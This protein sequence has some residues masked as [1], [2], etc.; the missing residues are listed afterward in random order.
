MA[1]NV[2]KRAT[3]VVVRQRRVETSAPGTGGSGIVGA[4]DAKSETP[5]SPNPWPAEFGWDFPFDFPKR[6]R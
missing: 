3:D 5:Q 6:T 2:Q 4:A 1:S